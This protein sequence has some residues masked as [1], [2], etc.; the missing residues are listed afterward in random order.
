MIAEKVTTEDV[1]NLMKG[2]MVVQLPN[3]HACNSAKS[4]LT[5]VRNAYSDKIGKGKILTASINAAEST[6]TIEYANE[7]KRLERVVGESKDQ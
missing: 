5:Y 6:I 7:E 2:K 3:Y 1:L 4:L